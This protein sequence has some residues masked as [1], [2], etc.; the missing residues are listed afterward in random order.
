MIRIARK[1]KSLKRCEDAK[2]DSEKM[3]K[4]IRDAT[5]TKPKPNITP[6][7]IKVKATDGTVKKIQ[8]R[9][10]IANEMNRQFCEMGAKLPSLYLTSDTFWWFDKHHSPPSTN[11]RNFSFALYEKGAEVS[12]PVIAKIVTSTVFREIAMV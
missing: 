8:N 5:N 7:F 3:W 9:T 12:I 4:V 6:D 1:Q 2:G 10:E 11:F